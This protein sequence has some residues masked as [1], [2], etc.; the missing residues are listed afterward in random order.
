MEDN[1]KHNVGSWLE[2]K[3]VE[4]HVDIV[5]GGDKADNASQMRI[6]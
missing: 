6:Y 5:V 2:V 4:E 3:H 1:Q